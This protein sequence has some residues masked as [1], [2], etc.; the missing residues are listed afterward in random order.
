MGSKIRTR[1]LEAKCD[2]AA[3]TSFG[4]C[5]LRTLVDATS[6]TSRDRISK[7]HMTAVSAGDFCEHLN[8]RMPQP[9]M[10]SIC[11]SSSR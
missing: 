11:K 2:G 5:N 8:I 7:N 9:A 10:P 3:I 6:R 1:K 4:V